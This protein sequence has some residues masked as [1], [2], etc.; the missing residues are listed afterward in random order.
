M[1]FSLT[2]LAL[3]VG[4]PQTYD[5][6]QGTWTSGIEKHAV[7]EPVQ[8]GLSQ[9]AGDGQADLEHH[10]GLDK[11]IYCYPSEHYPAWREELAR[12]ELPY[13][14][15][16]ENFTTAGLLEA[17]VCVGDT[18]RIGEVVVQVSQPRWPCWKL[19]RLWAIPDLDARVDA[20]RRCGWYLRVLEPG[21]VE[22]GLAFQLIERTQ[23]EWNIERIY[24]IT[25]DVR[26]HA[27]EAK[28]LM[29][30]ETLAASWRNAIASLG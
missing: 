26:G 10:G 28:E 19:N 30:L 4:E 11:A 29:A 3:Q 2:L 5:D 20:A 21:W 23:P 16:G 15:F 14:G 7:S 13:G 9:L 22:A 25:Q 17:Q 18:W 24:R 1:T 6:P 12:P 27:A 8:A